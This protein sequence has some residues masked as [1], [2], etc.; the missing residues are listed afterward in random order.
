MYVLCQINEQ[1]GEGYQ[2]EPVV[3]DGVVVHEVV[4][5]KD[6][7]VAGGGSQG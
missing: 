3:L 6:G 7:Q 1:T 4:K 2:L 5:Q